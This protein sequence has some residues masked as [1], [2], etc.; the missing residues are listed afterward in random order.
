MSR[1]AYH[2]VKPSRTLSCEMLEDRRLLAVVTSAADSGPGTL[3]D[4]LASGDPTI[5]FDVMA[6]GTDTIV[7]TSG[8]LLVTHDVAIDGDDGMGGRVT[9]D[10]GGNHR[11][12]MT[13]SSSNFADQSISNMIITNGYASTDGGGIQS[14]ENLTLDNVLISDN[15]SLNDGGGLGFG[16]EGNLAGSLVITNSR[17][18]NNF[19]RDDAGGI[20]FYNGLS[21]LIDNSVLENNTAGLLSEPNVAGAKVGGAMRIIDIFGVAGG[22]TSVI[23]NSIIT[24][25]AIAGSANGGTVSGTA[26]GIVIYDAN[27]NNGYPS[28]MDFTIRDSTV[29][30][31]YIRLGNPNLYDALV[32]YAVAGGIDANIYNVSVE[33][34]DFLGNTASIEHAEDPSAPT[35][36]GSLGSGYGG[37]LNFDGYNLSIT[38]ST[39]DGNYAYTRGSG[40]SI[41]NAFFGGLAQVNP[42]RATLDDVS[43]VNNSLGPNGRQANLG[44]GIAL[45]NYETIYNDVEV[46]ITNSTVTGNAADLGGGIASSNGVQLTI[47]DANVLGNYAAVHG[48]GIAVIGNGETADVVINRTTIADNTATLNG[49]GLFLYDEMPNMTSAMINNSTVSG[50]VGLGDTSNP[51]YQDLGDGGGIFVDGVVF[52]LNQSTVS[53]NQSP[54]DGGGIFFEYLVQ[55]AIIRQS[56]IYGNSADRDNGGAG[57]GVGVGGGIALSSVNFYAVNVTNSVISGNT[58]STGPNEIDDGGTGYLFTNNSFVG[59]GALLGPLQLNAGGTT[60]THQ[61]LPGSPLIDAGDDMLAPF[62]TDQNGSNRIIGASVDLGSVEVEAGPDCDFDDDGDYDCDDLD[63]LTKQI[64]GGGNDPAFDL[65]GDGVIDLLDLEIWRAD[66]GAWPDNFAITGGNPFLA[67][68]ANCDG[69]VDAADFIAWN[70]NK[71]TATANNSRGDFNASG[72]VDGA[73]F[74]IWQSN[75]F[76]TSRRD[77]QVDGGLVAP[78]QTPNATSHASQL[79]MAIKDDVWEPGV[80]SPVGQTARDRSVHTMTKLSSDVLSRQ[81]RDETS[82]HGWAHNGLKQSEL[83]QSELAQSIDWL[84]AEVWT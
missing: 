53:Y 45:L 24:E 74:M 64:A 37:A 1:R 29:S 36:N 3:R 59:Q 76:Q 40:I 8:D 60:A 75:K 67:G 28:Q 12:L 79:A 54:T 77:V 51:A 18:A 47:E 17:I 34:V 35:T 30:Y 50:N 83:G 23:Q 9:V 80:D 63:M 81:H 2:L 70:S 11:V 21:L 78:L 71:F 66:A 13:D 82:R 4:A 65:N 27:G 73:D 69:A 72:F 33:N 57:N 44:G 68:D 41:T 46:A 31:N 62:A 19:S 56:T 49:A 15:Y 14:F 25:N 20:D 26:A 38:N 16:D 52:E 84:M 5:T 10:G 7:L 58:D 48:G 22:Q 39:F 32:P 43:V 6:M 55:D 42:V 61:P